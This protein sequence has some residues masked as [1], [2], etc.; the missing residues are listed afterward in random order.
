M[1]QRRLG[2]P[3]IGRALE[4]LP[5]GTG[6]IKVLVQPMW[7]GGNML[8]M[9]GEA[10]TFRNDILLE[11]AKATASDTS[12]DSAGL[13]FVGSAWNGSSANDVSLSI[14]NTVLGNGN[15]RLSLQND[16]GLDVMT[17]GS[18][19]DLALAGNFYPSDRG[20]LQ[21]GAYVYY[22]ST[23]AG[24]MSTNAAGWL[25]NSS[26]FAESFASTDLLVPGDVVEFAVDGPG[27]MR[28]SGE[29]YS[30]RVAGVVS[31]RSA[32]VAGSS[33]GTYPVAVSGRVSV[34]VTDEN[35]AI[36]RGD[37]LT[38]SS[39]S[40]FAM[41]A[42]DSG[43]ILGYALEPLASG[44][45]EILV[46]V[47]PQ[48]AHGSSVKN[49]SSLA[50]GSQDIEN[51]NVSGVLSMNGGDIVSV[52]TLSGIGTWEI[53]ENGDI[54][55]NGQLT[56]VV[57]SLQNTR[58][59][60]YATTSTETIVQLSGTSTL[61]G[62]MARVNFEDIDQ[63]YNDVISPDDTYRVLVTP[64]GITGQLYVTDRSNAGFIIRD[65]G[66][67]EGVS[68][69]WLVLAYR[70]DLVPERG[71]GDVVSDE[72]VKLG[73]DEVSETDVTDGGGVI[74]P[75][76]VV[77]PTEEDESTGEELVNGG[78]G[79]DPDDRARP[80]LSEGKDLETF[81]EGSDG[82]VVND[83]QEEFLNE[84]GTLPEEIPESPEIVSENAP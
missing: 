13:S 81:I 54:V 57:E 21:Y 73:S 63:N 38:T 45:G 47:R 76:E 30:E 2:A 39:R 33:S 19:G 34:K 71:N 60:T 20:A 12:V 52:G 8:T 53:R 59:S 48:Y 10:A 64:N 40:G 83:N 66:Q 29:A 25:S 61:H 37:A 62:G 9:D 1:L 75:E 4:A 41:K 74:D 65:I 17:F 69:D 50:I 6:T 11:G 18:T 14:R 78:E 84:A 51:L 77:S 7:Y 15:A 42:T 70:Y 46:F 24:Y 23:N 16:D 35:G 49:V 3:I 55:T 82:E 56:Q 31:S 67:G 26:S 80:E 79:K 43:Q 28:S 72:V 44:E 68:V 27:V 36:A 22:D 5:S 58:V 32:F